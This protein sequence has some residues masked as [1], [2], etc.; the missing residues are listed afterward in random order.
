LAPRYFGA[1]Q[2]LLVTGIPWRVISDPEH[3]EGLQVL[4]AFGPLP[5]G[6]GPFPGLEVIDVLELAGWELPPPSLLAR[7]PALRRIAAFMVSEMYRANFHHR[8]ARWL[9]DHA[10]LVHFFLQSPY[11][12]LVPESSRHTL[13]ATLGQ[14]SWPHLSAKE[15]VLIEWWRQ[16]NSQQV[17]LVNYA[18]HRQ[19]VMVHFGKTVTGQVLSPDD[20][21][22]SFETEEISLSLN[23]YAVI[24]YDQKGSRS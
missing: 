10:G 8:C 20:T 3:L 11:F 24:C 7:R 9:L 2:T 15:P 23:V 14:G 19:E 16:G 21:G 1:G 13:L 22:W 12:R 4:L 17:H 18:S 5:P 6:F